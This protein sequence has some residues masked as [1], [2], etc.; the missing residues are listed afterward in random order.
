MKD[1]LA[2]QSDPSFDR[3]ERAFAI[4]RGTSIVTEF[5]AVM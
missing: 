2:R 1:V 3:F 5:K 4:D